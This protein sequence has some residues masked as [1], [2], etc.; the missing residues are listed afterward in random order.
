MIS[1]VLPLL[2]MLVISLPVAGQEQGIA[3]GGDPDAD[4]GIAEAAQQ[5][6]APGPDTETSAEVPAETGPPLE[7]QPG[8]Q[9]G[10]APAADAGEPAHAGAPVEIAPA[11][12]VESVQEEER[13]RSIII[14]FAAI[15]LIAALVGIIVL[16]IRRGHELRPPHA[17]VAEAYLNDL[18]GGTSQTTY[19]LGSK[20][21][22]LGRVA[23]KDTEHLDYIVIPQSTIGRRHAL[24]EYKDFAYWIMDQ[25]SINGTFVNDKAVSS[26]I[27]LK[28]GDRVRL[29]KYQF[30]FV[31]P[32]V[33][34]TG[35]TVVSET[36]FAGR[37]VPQKA[38][39]AMSTEEAELLHD[40]SVSEE[41]APGRKPRL[42]GEEE[43]LLPSRGSGRS[44]AADEET[45]LPA[46][47]APRPTSEDETLLPGGTSGDEGDKAPD[48]EDDTLMPGASPPPTAA[49]GASKKK[50]GNGS[51]D[52]FFDIT[53]S[54]QDAR[55]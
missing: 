1:R 13:T 17:Y 40:L 18:Q 53:G 46:G 41:Q 3:A 55:K 25:G 28:H 51:G 19:K 4:P 9:P 24:I 10:F 27:R 21:I 42:T 52:D 54:D 50:E 2:L 22:M 39:A 34:E 5:P 15:A 7:S 20:P 32:D 48:S 23:G 31:M 33:A 12:Q 43:T 26:E 45:L 29:H 14:L 6:A 49:R 11:Q 37:G 44:A 36:G 38:A 16:L 47:G 35:K 8:L 30:E